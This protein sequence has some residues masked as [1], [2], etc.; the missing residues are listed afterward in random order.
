MP[1]LHLQSSSAAIAFACSSVIGS[2]RPLSAFSGASTVTLGR[3]DSVEPIVSPLRL[4]AIVK[5]VD[6]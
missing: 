6:Y 3:L 2:P 1:S 5:R 4:D